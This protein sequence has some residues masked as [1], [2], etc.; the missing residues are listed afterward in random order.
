MAR[1]RPV[2]EFIDRAFD[3]HVME[4]V[5]EVRSFR[6]TNVRIKR[7][8]VSL[9]GATGCKV[10][11]RVTM[12]RS[13]ANSFGLTWRPGQLMLTGDLGE[14]TIPHYALATFAGISWA[15]SSDH[16]YL[17]GKTKERKEY[18]PEETLREIR[19][20]LDRPV[21]EFLNGERTI[22]HRW[23]KHHDGKPTQ[24]PVQTLDIR[25]PGFRHELQE[26]R[27]ACKEAALDQE[28]MDEAYVPERP[29][30]PL[31]TEKK[32]RYSWQNHRDRSAHSD[33]DIPDHLE[34]WAK[35][36]YAVGEQ[37]DLVNTREGRARV[38]GEIDI[39][40]SGERSDAVEFLHRAGYDD[41]YG[42]EKWNDRTYWQI[43]A[44]QHGVAM[45]YLAEFPDS[46]EAG[47][48]RREG[49]ASR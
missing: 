48:I 44:I 40:V 22:R 14:L 18:D 43:A 37:C 9:V 12:E 21:I 24:G 39:A 31:V 13:G 16:D 20:D 1:R 4:E 46:E 34:M 19:R 2:H 42:S 33:W 41:W 32:D 15:L 36:A 26:W 6:F 27:I 28:E 35:A 7:S 17:M 45:I 47:R 29:E 8:V 30:L 23:P 5:R 38:W 11:E 3:T 25:V 10:E 49:R